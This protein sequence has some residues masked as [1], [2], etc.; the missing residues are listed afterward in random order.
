MAFK[1][2]HVMIV[3]GKERNLFFFV[4]LPVA[5]V[6]VPELGK[7][8]SIRSLKCWRSGNNCAQGMHCCCWSSKSESDERHEEAFCPVSTSPSS[9]IVTARELVSGMSSRPWVSG[10][11]SDSA[12]V[13]DPLIRTSFNSLTVACNYHGMQGGPAPEPLNSWSATLARAKQ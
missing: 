3:L 5:A 12:V 1:A 8:A 10:W 7:T 9:N 11:S 6:E 2:W 4:R 13:T